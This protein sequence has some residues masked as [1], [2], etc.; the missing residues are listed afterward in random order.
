MG[1]RAIY[2][3]RLS[4]GISGVLRAGA[5]SVP[6]FRRHSPF[7]PDGLSGSSGLFVISDSARADIPAL[8][9]CRAYLQSADAFIAFMASD[10]DLYIALPTI[11]I[12]LPS[13]FLDTT[14]HFF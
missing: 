13:G 4:I 1:C 8:A 2:C 14:L 5:L 7:S 11:I 9:I 10:F 3:E 6:S 12:V